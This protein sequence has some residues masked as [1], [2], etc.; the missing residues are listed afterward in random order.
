MKFRSKALIGI[1]LLAGLLAMSPIFAFWVGT[2]IIY[3]SL[4][5]EIESDIQRARAH[6]V[7]S[8]KDVL[9][10]IIRT[11][12]PLFWSKSPKKMY[13]KLITGEDSKEIQRESSAI[14]ARV[15]KHYLLT[16]RQK[17]QIQRMLFWHLSGLLLI[18]AIEYNVDKTDLIRIA[19][20]IDRK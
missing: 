12:D 15:C 17:G 9:D 8:N 14:Y 13:W 5:S 4:K 1:G 2:H 10:S 3:S 18:V 6:S 19:C 16:L 20:L 11:Y 7:C